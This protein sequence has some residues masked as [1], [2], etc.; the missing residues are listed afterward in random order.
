MAVRISKAGGDME[1]NAG[2]R[3]ESHLGSTISGVM[4]KMVDVKP[5]LAGMFLAAGV[6]GTA[7]PLLGLSSTIAIPATNIAMRAGL[8]EIVGSLAGGALA[9]MLLK[10]KS[11]AGN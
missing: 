5:F 9:A 7:S 3:V 11:S 6:L 1:R 2:R 8:V 10:K 4:R